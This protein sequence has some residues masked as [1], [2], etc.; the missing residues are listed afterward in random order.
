MIIQINKPFLPEKEAYNQL[1]SK[2]WD[3]QWLTNSGPYA[4]DLEFLLKKRFDVN[5]LLF[6]SSGTMALQIS[7]AALEL[8]GEIITTPFSFIATT[9]SIIITA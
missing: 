9:T 1:I 3:N 6:V 5:Q 2:I 8:E 4:V 7:I